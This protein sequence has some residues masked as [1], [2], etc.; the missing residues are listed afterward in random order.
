MT[1]SEALNVRRMEVFVQSVPNCFERSSWMGHITGSA[2]VLNAKESAVVLLHHRKLGMWLQP[3]G[4]ADGDPD[5]RG[6]AQREVQEETGLSAPKLRFDE[7]FDV[8]IHP[9]PAR[10]RKNEQRAEGVHFHYDVRWV[11][12]VSEGEELISNPESHSVAWVPL[13]EISKYTQE[14]S[15]LRMLSKWKA[16]A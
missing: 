14:K 10:P 5:I 11:F 12:Q 7:I 13:D 3:G 4:H 1:S 9:I 16:V 8:D 2:W 6:V 15:I